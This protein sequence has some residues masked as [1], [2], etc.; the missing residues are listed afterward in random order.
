M[1]LLPPFFL[2]TVVA[3]GFAVHGKT[4]YVATGFLLGRLERTEDNGDRRFRIFLVTN[5][6][7]FAEQARA[8]VRFNPES[9]DDAREYDIP[10]LTSNGAPAWVTHPSKDVDLAVIGI[11][12]AL[13]QEHGIRFRFFENDRHMLSL[14]AAKDKGLSEGDGVFALGFPMGMIGE[15][16]DFVIVRQGSIAR[17]QDALNGASNEILIDMTIFPGNSGGP[18]VTRPELVSIEGTQPIGNASLVGVI[19]SYVPYQDVAVSLQT[20]RPRVI[21]EENSGLASVVPVDR[22]LEIVDHAVQD[23]GSANTPNAVDNRES[24]TVDDNQKEPSDS[25]LALG[26]TL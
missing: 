25:P 2:D 9:G 14:A 13:L 4:T 26:D 8:Y 17:I 15:K 23:T 22:L 21:F 12:A 20:K 5:K 16:R 7:V 1:A 6:H 19:A 18:V 10:L 11:N 24:T 3:I